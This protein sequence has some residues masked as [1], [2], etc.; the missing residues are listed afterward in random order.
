MRD[1]C[2]IKVSRNKRTGIC[3]ILNSMGPS[4]LWLELLT[5]KKIC[6]EMLYRTSEY[7]VHCKHDNES[8]GSTKGGELL[9]KLTV[10]FSGRTLLHVGR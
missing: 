5:V 7:A 3:N 6:Y 1:A 8:S 10:S 2:D 9:D 4:A